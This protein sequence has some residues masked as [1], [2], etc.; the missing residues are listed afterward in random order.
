MYTMPMSGKQITVNGM[1]PSSFI[2]LFSG[3]FRY[4]WKT[5]SILL[6]SSIT[7]VIIVVI[8]WWIVSNY[9]LKEKDRF[10]KILLGSML[11]SLLSEIVS[12]CVSLFTFLMIPSSTQDAGGVMYF[13]CFLLVMSVLSYVFLRVLKKSAKCAAILGV[14]VAIVLPKWLGLFSF[15]MM[16]SYVEKMNVAINM[17]KEKKLEAVIEASGKK[18]NISFTYPATYSKRESYNNEIVISRYTTRDIAV[19]FFSLSGV[20]SFDKS[21]PL[22]ESIKVALID[23]YQHPGGWV[24]PG[25]VLPPIEHVDIEVNGKK[26]MKFFNIVSDS[27]GDQ[28]IYYVPVD[29]PDL[30]IDRG[31]AK[32]SPITDQEMNVILGS[33][34]SRPI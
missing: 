4:D 34:V 22:A 28:G 32:T 30:F 19:R 25:N 23:T 15:G 2:S 7:N 33:F 21:V 1:F 10:L 24:A 11:L 27:M 6:F 20:P 12:Y 5:E 3:V 16:H 29:Q 26:Y 9:F 17:D 31:P 13:A 18:F 14:I 8:L